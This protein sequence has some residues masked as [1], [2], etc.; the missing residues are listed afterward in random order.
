[1]SPTPVALRGT[2]KP[3]GTLELERP[4]DLPPGPVRVTIQPDSSVPAI[5]RR[6]SLLDVLDAIHAAQRARGYH[7]RSIEEMNAD[8][9]RQRLEDQEEEDRWRAIWNRT[10]SG[11][12]P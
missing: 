7:G 5:L 10:N 1:M 8:E 3:D 11:G 4:P 12:S 6:P 9:V 2:L